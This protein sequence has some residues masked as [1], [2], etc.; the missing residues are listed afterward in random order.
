MSETEQHLREAIRLA[1]A[2]MEAGGR[3]FGAV[4]VKDGEVVA[5]GVN[6]ILTTNDPTAH[7][8]LMAIRA[9]SHKL[10]SPSLAGAAVYASGHPCPMCMAAMR[11]AGVNEVYYAYSND[12]GA[13]VGLSTAA[14]YADLAKPFAEQSMTIRYVPVRPEGDADLYAAWAARQTPR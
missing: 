9:A 8:E 12:D 1:R 3:P 2:N 10:G 4:L 14:I 5:T 11:L 13:P 7:A 6:E